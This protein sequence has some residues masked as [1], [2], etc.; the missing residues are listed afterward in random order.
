[1]KYLKLNSVKF[2]LAGGIATALCVLVTLLSSSFGYAV[3]AGNIILGIYGFLG[4]SLSTWGI[5]LGTIYSFID[6][7]VLTWI[8]ALLYNW[9]VR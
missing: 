4:A 2:G 7:F 3:D 8:F 1:M 5:V 6:G 9:M